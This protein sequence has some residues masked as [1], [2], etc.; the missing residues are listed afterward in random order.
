MHLAR[1]HTEMSFPEIARHMGNKNHTTVILACRRIRHMLDE[2]AGARWM[3][4]AGERQ[5][6]LATLIHDLEV[7]LVQ[8]PGSVAASA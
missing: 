5:M 2:D 8:S 7:Q 1:K 6:K 3:T 4:P